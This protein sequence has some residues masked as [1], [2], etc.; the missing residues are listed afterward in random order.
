MTPH[1]AVACDTLSATLPRPI[2]QA[3]IPPG[4][5]VPHGP[6]HIGVCQEPAGVDE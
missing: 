4:A 1:D 3:D 2:M 6:Q 5:A